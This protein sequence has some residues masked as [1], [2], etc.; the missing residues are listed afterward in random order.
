MNDVIIVTCIALLAFGISAFLA[1]QLMDTRSEVKSLVNNVDAMW[2]E[3]TTHRK[4][5]L[6]LEHTLKEAE[7]DLDDVWERLAVVEDTLTMPD[8]REETPEEQEEREAVLANLSINERILMRESEFDRRISALKKSD[9]KVFHPDVH[10][11]PHEAV[12]LVDM[13]LPDVEDTD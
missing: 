11:I 6:E 4:Q 13:Q 9:A 2:R 12:D 1:F 5:I 10:N 3:I 8:E 7:I